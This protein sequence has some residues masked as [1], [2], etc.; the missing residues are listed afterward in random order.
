[1]KAA[2]WLANRAL[3][4][5]VTGAV[6]VGAVTLL[7]FVFH[8]LGRLPYH[9]SF[10]N[11][12]APEWQAFGGIWQI[13]H[14]VMRNESDE[15]GARLVTGNPRWQDYV[16]EADVRL[17][18]QGGD[19]GLVVRSNN[20][21]L[22]VDAYEGYYVGLRT[23]DNSL[24][25]GRSSY[26]W[27]EGEPTPVPGG[28]HALS[29]Y[30]IRI[31]AAGCSIG[32]A[33]V[34]LE[35]GDKAYAALQESPC[36]KSGRIG[37][38]SHATG[39]EWRNIRV[40]SARGLD[41]AEILHHVNRV[42]S[43]LFP[44]DEAG[45]NATHSF[46][47]FDR[48]IET[49]TRSSANAH[50][51]ALPV[52]NLGSLKLASPKRVRARGVVTLTSPALYIQDA[53][54]GATVLGGSRPRLNLGDEIEVVGTSQPLGYSTAFH[55][56]AVRRLWDRTPY[57]PI[58]VTASQAA[59]GAYDAMLIETQGTLVGKQYQDDRVILALQNGDQSFQAIA[60]RG[61]SD[62]PY[63]RLSPHSLLRLRGICLLDAKY[64]RGLAPF[65]IW[66]R[67]GDDFEVIAG[68]PWWTKKHLTELGFVI[69][70]LTLAAQLLFSSMEKWRL[71]AITQ[72]RERLAYE[73]HDTLAQSFAGIGYQLQGIRN[74]IRSLALDGLEAISNQLEMVCENVRKAHQEASLSIAMLRDFSP[75][76]SDL[77]GALER[78]ASQ[79]CFG[80]KMAVEVRSSGQV[81]PLSLQAADALFHI[82]REALANALGHAGASRVRAR[83]D[84]S[85]SLVTLTV[86][87]NGVGFQ[88]QTVS[89][90]L[91]LRGME[92]RAQDI[93]AELFI[94]SKPGFGTRV[95]VKA[96]LALRR[97]YTGYLA[98]FGESI[99]KIRLRLAE[100]FK[101]NRLLFR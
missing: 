58:S 100:G 68:P 10:G 61:R 29:W 24:I 48:N 43:P 25:I 19:V 76:V 84:Y 57:P 95:M 90:G 2:R 15:R 38:R 32:G 21:S 36:V 22:G 52:T 85:P 54:G 50:A 87:D 80:G 88:T 31:V 62:L 83:V 59:T 77:A 44:R 49:E 16:L 53:T 20:E 12:L 55:D 66:L 73:L 96:P 7:F 91:G 11:N 45:Y 86:E 82:G 97:D 99:R 64:T 6:L 39:G 34:N 9:D 78:C 65:A 93:K 72:E 69:L 14:Q 37:L 18:S 101:S 74:R 35:T 94:R 47:T 75:E 98:W 71:R 46:P 8:P 4:I 70:L 26:G 27:M 56:V 89:H 33:A 3:W 1:M 5:D 41:L 67:S 17:L 13:T 81:R 30:H 92:K 63:R 40:V 51:A 60:R 42:T 23:G 79:M 28:V